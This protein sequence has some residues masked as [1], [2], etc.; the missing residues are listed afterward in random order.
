MPREPPVI[1]AALPA[2]EIMFPPDEFKKLVSPISNL[3]RTWTLRS[4]SELRSRQDDNPKKARRRPRPRAPERF[5]DSADSARNDSEKLT[6]TQRLAAERFLAPLGMTSGGNA[7]TASRLVRNFQTSFAR[8]GDKLREKFLREGIF[9]H[10]F[11]M[12]LNAND[13]VLRRLQFHTFDDSVS[14]AR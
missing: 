8:G 13:P 4:F 7:A 1:S 14:A 2:K 12:P 5:L 6:R 3:C 9:R 10:A 11:G